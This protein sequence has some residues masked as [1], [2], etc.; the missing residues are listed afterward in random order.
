MK[1]V[2]ASKVSAQNIVGDINFT[3][4]T[5]GDEISVPGSL[6]MRKNQVIRLQ[7]FIPILGTEVGRL[8]FTPEDVLIMD[9]MHKEYVKADYSEVSF[10]KKNGI[11]FYSLQ[12][13]FWNQLMLPGTNEVK[14]SDATRFTTDVT[15]TKNLSLQAK[16][17]NL[18]STWIVSPQT[19][20][21][22]E[23]LLNYESAIIGASSLK[24]TYSDFRKVG[25]KQFPA[26]QSFNISTNATGKQQQALITL[27]MNNVK[28]DSKW[29]TVTTVSSKYKK[30]S[31][32]E[33]L[34][35][36]LSM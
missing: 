21:I 29:D 15:E 20:L 10:L 11:S 7:L 18:T 1:R 13:L 14:E 8:E 35:K 36:F 33:L 22:N 19:M 25:S 9:R 32:D 24:W 31:A 2:L 6:H 27:K 12:A 30:V 28:T 17:G 3:I 34:T 16:D 23:A 26:T 4:T 5:G